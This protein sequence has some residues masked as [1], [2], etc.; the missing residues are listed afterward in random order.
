MEIN[1]RSAI[2]KTIEEA[3]GVVFEVQAVKAC[4]GGCINDA[5]ILYGE[6]GSYFIKLNAAARLEM[7][8]AEAAG[9]KAMRATET[10]YVPEPIAFGQFEDTAYLILERLEF[11]GHGDWQEMGRQLARLHRHTAG[12]FGWECDNTIGSTPQHNPGTDAWPDFFRDHRLGFQLNL[13]RQNG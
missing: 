5:A 3:V 2:R 7:F 12:R 13:A 6:T 8:V 9:L 1:L 4:G 11:G 10:I